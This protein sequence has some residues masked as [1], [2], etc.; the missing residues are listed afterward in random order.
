MLS[1]IIISAFVGWILRGNTGNNKETG[2]GK[3]SLPVLWLLLLANHYKCFGW[4]G[5]NRV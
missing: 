2:A 3:R 4:Y 1:W 5:I